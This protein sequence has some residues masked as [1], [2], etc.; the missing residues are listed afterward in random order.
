MLLVKLCKIRCVHYKYPDMSL[1]AT[2]HKTYGSLLFLQIRTTTGYVCT[3][4][5]VHI[6]LLNL[7][8]CYHLFTHHYINAIAIVFKC[9]C[10]FFRTN[11]TQSVV[12]LSK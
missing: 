4:A 9:I 11:N 2:V 12:N 6:S 7:V 1:S 3:H 8:S 10:P 5:R